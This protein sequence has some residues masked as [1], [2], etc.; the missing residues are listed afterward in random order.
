[1][2]TNEHRARCAR[3]ALVAYGI[4]T[5]ADSTDEALTD[6]LADLLHFA[7]A[8]AIK[9][10]HDEDDAPQRVRDLLNRAWMHY[11]EEDSATRCEECG[12]DLTPDDLRD[13]A[14]ICLG[15]YQLSRH[16]EGGNNG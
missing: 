12:V 15:C 1:M 2:R 11:E 14:T 9:A 3:V 8:A 7:H 5:G 4:Y 13:E 16:I 6:L 10:G